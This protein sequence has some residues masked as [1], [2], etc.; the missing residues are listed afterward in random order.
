M[1]LQIIFCLFCI[2][3]EFF[4]TIVDRIQKLCDENNTKI[5]PL[6]RSLGISTGTIG[7]WDTSSPSA[8]RLYKVAE[9]FSVSMEWLLTGKDC[10]IEKF[11]SNKE[12]EFLSKYRFL[13]DTDRKRINDYITF[14]NIADEHFIQP[15]PTKE[16]LPVIGCVAAGQ[17]ILAIENPLSFTSRINRFVSYALYIRGDSME[18]VI[19]D[20]ETVQVISQKVL[21]NGEIGIIKID[22]SVTCKKF[23]Y[24]DFAI[25]LVSFNPEYKPL[26]YDSTASNDVQILGKVV[27]TDEQN[28]RLEN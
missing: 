2:E 3:G 6:E 14:C 19:K 5:R 22:D 4:M 20:G 9:Y 27:L 13:P 25:K 23:Y 12:L 1:F 28:A 18:P 21:E 8:D 15:E 11:L 17:P 24:D 16:D 26:I 7:K 10:G